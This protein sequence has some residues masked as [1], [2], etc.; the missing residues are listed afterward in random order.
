MSSCCRWHGCQVA[1]MPTA[2]CQENSRWVAQ[3]DGKAGAQVTWASHRRTARTAPQQSSCSAA[4]THLTLTTPFQLLPRWKLK[5]REVAVEQ[6][7]GCRAAHFCT[8]CFSVACPG[9]GLDEVQ[10]EGRGLHSLEK[11]GL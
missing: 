1:A 7:S 6:D 8:D 5:K 4:A 2:A 10:D 11:M 3:A 9:C